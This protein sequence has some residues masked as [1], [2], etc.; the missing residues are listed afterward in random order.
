M[1]ENVI[2]CY[3]TPF[4]LFPSSAVFKKKNIYIF[5]LC[6]TLLCKPLSVKEPL[7]IPLEH[8]FILQISILCTFIATSLSKFLVCIMWL[9]SSLPVSLTFSSSFASPCLLVESTS[10][11]CSVYTLWE[12]LFQ[13]ANCLGRVMQVPLGKKGLFC[14][15]NCEAVFLSLPPG[16]F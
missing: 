1:E 7:P 11:S 2:P 13:T 16:V 14:A 3:I 4:L 6:G 12:K 8:I 15:Q 5:S 10:T 9:L